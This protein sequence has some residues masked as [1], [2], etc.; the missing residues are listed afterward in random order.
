VVDT[1]DFLDLP[2]VV[3]LHDEARRQGRDVISAF[4]CGWGAVS[5]VFRHDGASLRDVFGLP[6]SGDLQGATY[7]AVF[8]DGLAR[9][10]PH[11]PQDFVTETAA[12][13]RG[14]VEGRPCPAPQLAAGTASAASVTMAQAVRLL[15]G[16]A[17]TVAP[18]VVLLDIGA[19]IRTPGLRVR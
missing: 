7:P 10:A 19:T 13:L 6:T 12:A 14:M 17:Q 9:L 18:E 1:I 5:I 8:A 3:G 11:L 15:G 4:A 16:S 2:A